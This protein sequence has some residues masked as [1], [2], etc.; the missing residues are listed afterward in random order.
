MLPQQS[1]KT[2]SFSQMVLLNSVVFGVEICAC[3]GFTCI[4]PLLL[5]VGYS[6]ENMSIILGM[7]P[8]LCLIIVP[9]MGRASDQCKSKYGRRR[10]FIFWIS[11]LILLSLVFILSGDNLYLTEQSEVITTSHLG[12]FV[13]TAGVILLDFSTQSL[14]TPCEALLSDASEGTDQKERIFTIYSFMVSFGG[15]VGYLITALDWSNSSL[16][17]YFGGQEQ[18]IFAILLVLYL[19]SSAATLMIAEET[20]QLQNSQEQSLL[21]SGDVE[22]VPLVTNNIHESGYETSSNESISDDNTTSATSLKSQRTAS[23]TRLINSSPVFLSKVISCILSLTLLTVKLPI[24]CHICKYSKRLIK[25]LW[26]GIYHRLPE[27]IQAL[28]DIPFVLRQLAAANFCSWTAVMGFTL[29]YT[30]YVGQAVYDGNP[31]APENSLS[32]NNF[33]EGVR[34]GSWGLLLHCMTS[35]AYSPFIERL[36]ERYGCRLTY[37]CGMASFSLAMFIMVFCHNIIIVNA[38]A[39]VTGFGYATLTTIPF[40]L[41]SDYHADKAVFFFD[42]ERPTSNA[43]PSHSHQI[44]GIA[45]DMAILDSTYF[46]SQVILSGLMG[47]VVHLTGTV[48]S[49]ILTA[50]VMGLLSCLFSTKI[51][52][53]KQEILKYHRHPRTRTMIV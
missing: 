47:Y 25:S 16:G 18:S 28:L 12:I 24:I 7:G 51:I 4:S 19:L 33:D 48:L 11:L 35:A 15:C 21:Y 44:R 1:R 8:L 50:G 36:V 38:V 10:P 46:L 29:F 20:P 2:L 45:M 14:L 17:H 30:D 9:L 22:G 5:K 49:Y 13:L 27:N 52:I 39:A 43:S 34:M 23:K 26:T 6:E 41:V 42:V 53:N 40:I 3:A 37:L 32:R 31:N